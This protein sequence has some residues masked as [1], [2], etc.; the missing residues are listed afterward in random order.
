MINAKTSLKNLCRNILENEYK[1]ADKVS[2]LASVDSGK[3]GLRAVVTANDIGGQYAYDVFAANAGLFMASLVPEIA[4]TIA[5]DEAMR[6][7]YNWKRRP[8]ER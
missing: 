8:F 4:G 5:V 6:L 2:G 1:L 3:Q 7:G